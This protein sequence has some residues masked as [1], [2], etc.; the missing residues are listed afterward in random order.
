MFNKINILQI[1][2]DHFATLRD[3]GT[4]KQRVSDYLLFIGIP[5]LLSLVA[6][7]LK[8]RLV[9]DII[10]IL[11]TS[12]SIFAA[13]LLNLLLLIFDIVRKNERNI[14]GSNNNERKLE[15][16]K[17][18]YSNISYSILIS[19]LT[20]IFL[21]LLNFIKNSLAGEICTLII[22]TFLIN[23]ILSLLMILKRVHSLLS[24]EIVPKK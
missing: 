21:M 7:F 16:L 3:Y 8:L 5:L 23:F 19:I 1:I 17:E 18:I 12:L 4:K 13:L 24:R 10:N 11:I 15:F 9:N 14:D 22:F 2:K 20:L 6:W